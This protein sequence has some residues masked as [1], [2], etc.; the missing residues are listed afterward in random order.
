MPI[1][2]RFSSAVGEVEI[3]KEFQDGLKDIKGFSH[4]M[5]LYWFHKSKGFKLH[6]RP[7]LDDKEKGIFAIRSPNRPNPIGVSVVKLK[8]V[9]GNMLT[10]EG[11]DTLD[12]T[13]LI[14]IKPYVPEFETINS[15]S[16]GWLKRK[17]REV[18]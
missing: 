16:I 17:I 8:N 14:D 12:N 15:E 6:A 5:L 3:F 18:K 13:P 7:F 9:K 11:L 10:V 1:Q 4:I 2:P